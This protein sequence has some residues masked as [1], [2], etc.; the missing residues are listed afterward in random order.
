MWWRTLLEVT[1]RM[2]SKLS[3]KYVWMCK[4]MCARL[5]FCKIASKGSKCRECRRSDQ[6]AGSS[7]RCN[8]YCDICPCLDKRVCVIEEFGHKVSPQYWFLLP[9]SHIRL[10]NVAT[11][12]NSR[13]PVKCCK[14]SA[15]LCVILQLMV[16]LGNHVQQG[17][18]PTGSCVIQA[19]VGSLPFT[20]QLVPLN[21]FI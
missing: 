7:C 10:A 17:V 5:M 12:G 6:N 21:L 20:V 16:K 4:V 8:K 18:G 15:P 3:W 13:C 11:F 19:W 9:Y 2:G 1:V 14:E